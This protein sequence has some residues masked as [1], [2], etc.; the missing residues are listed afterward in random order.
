MFKIGSMDNRI[1]L[2]TG[3]SRGLGRAVAKCFARSGATVVV[4]AR[5]QGALEELDT[6]IQG[7]GLPPLI[8]AP[9]DITDPA[10][11]DKLAAS[12]SERFGRLDILVGAAGILGGLRPM[13]HVEP[14]MFDKVIATNLTA[15]WR[16]IRNFDALLR[17][18]EAGRAIFVTS[19]V[20]RE[21]P[22]FWGPYTIA[23]AGLEAMI[24][25]Y[26]A[27]MQQTNVNTN[28][29]DPGGIR[30][31]M[32]SEAF[33]GENPMAL[34]TPETVTSI[35]HELA[36]PQCTINGEVVFAQG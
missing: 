23:K 34:P 4:T 24:R 6:E 32:R 13:P 35:F 22:A 26:A 28:L 8:L 16:L 11:I 18:S 20:T 10:N 30:S 2:V 29:V 31:R 17:L 33:P 9:L 25:T 5:T 36:N 3:A 1:A 14:N 12:I 21:L 19:G 7:L 15:N 27:E